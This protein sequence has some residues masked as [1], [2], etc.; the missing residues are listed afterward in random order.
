MLPAQIF[1]WPVAGIGLEWVARMPIRRSMWLA[2][3]LRALLLITAV[4]AGGAAMRAT[5]A[6]RDY[7]RRVA[8]TL[9][10]LPVRSAF[11]AEDSDRDR[12]LA[13]VLSRSVPPRRGVFAEAGRDAAIRVPQDRATIARLRERGFDVFAQPAARRHLEAFGVRFEPLRTTGPALPE[14]LDLVPRGAIVAI[15]GGPGLS[16]V[17]LPPRG[18]PTFAAIGGRAQLFGRTSSPY[19]IVG[20]KGASEGAIE[21]VKGDGVDLRVDAGQEIGQTDELSPVILRAVASANGSRIVVN[22]ETLADAPDGLALVVL[23]PDGDLLTARTLRSNSRPELPLDAGLVP[24][25]RLTTI[26]PCTT[27]AEAAWT[28]V[29]SLAAASAAGIVAAQTE[30][31]SRVLL[32]FSSRY[33]LDPGVEYLDPRQDS[34]PTVTSYPAGAGTARRDVLARDGVP[35]SWYSD[36]DDLGRIEVRTR[37]SG[38]LLAAVN[39]GGVPRRAFARWQ[40]GL[41]ASASAGR[42]RDGASSSIELCP[43][44]LAG[45]R[46]FDGELQ[47][48]DLPLDDREL[49]GSGWHGLE[50]ILPKAF[51]WST[52]QDAVVLV[53]LARAGAVR[54]SIEAWPAAV[55]T[56]TGPR[57]TPIVNGTALPGQVMQARPRD[58]SWSVPAALWKVGANEVILSISRVVNPAAEGIGDDTRTLGVAVSRVRLERLD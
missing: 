28:D 14:Y 37:R 53:P 43:G 11:V 42:V 8:L 55:A 41:R 24:F 20:I 40:P 22:G 31:D 5:D 50:R 38:P 30:R 12:E 15:A 44:S 57:L 29:S 39:F 54:L 26:E 10:K 25:A 1:L 33:P 32:Y 2:A 27:L 35:S 9:E 13:R 16:Y 46:L 56:E 4:T 36:R 51:R 17:L 6:V 58:Y 45:H 47:R 49:F 34:P 7:R 52:R 48:E 3:A 19:A 21:E 23:S 18:A